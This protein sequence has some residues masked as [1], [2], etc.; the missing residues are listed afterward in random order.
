MSVARFIADQRTLYRV[1]HA[2][3][4]VLLGV[5]PAWFYKWLRRAGTAAPHTGAG[6]RRALVDAA[7]AKAFRAA[8]GVHGSPRLV[9]DLR[10]QGWKVSEKTVAES[11]RRQGL[12]ARGI[13]RRSGLTQQD[14]T[15]AKFPDLVKRDFSA[16]GPNRKWVGDLTEIPTGEDGRGAKLYLATVIDLYSRRLLGAATSRHPDAQLA[17]AAIQMAVLAT[18]GGR[19]DLAGRRSRAGD[20]PQPTAG[21]PTPPRPLPGY[22][23]G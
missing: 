6:R 21:P 18:R 23:P 12:V 4:C 5:S 9:D 2:V 17:G 1:P 14:K 15:A 10:E 16:T 11:M 22:A 20:L 3:V 8:R 19:G 7:V 13:R